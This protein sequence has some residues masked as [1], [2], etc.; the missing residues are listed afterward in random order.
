M[1][2]SAAQQSIRERDRLQ[3]ARNNPRRRNLSNQAR[4]PIDP[5]ASELEC[6][7]GRLWLTGKISKEQYSAGVRWRELSLKYLAAIGAP[8]PFTRSVCEGE[9][10]SKAGNEFSDIFE[11]DAWDDLES[12]E[13]AYKRVVRL[14][15]ARGR[16]VF[17][18]VQSI[19]VYEEPEEL[20]DFEFTLHA[21]KIGLSEIAANF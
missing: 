21:A 6:P 4:N 12:T 13:V 7:L 5:L 14:L 15:K 17:H 2:T 18:A 11:S 9:V 1:E 16:R 8:Y 3:T 20:G 19:V 10:I